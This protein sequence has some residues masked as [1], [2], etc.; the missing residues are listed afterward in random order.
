RIPCFKV[1]VKEKKAKKDIKK[2]EIV[3]AE[4]FGFKTDITEPTNGVAIAIDSKNYRPLIGG[5]QIEGSGS[6]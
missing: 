5:S 2:T 3:P 1:T 4:I 6:S